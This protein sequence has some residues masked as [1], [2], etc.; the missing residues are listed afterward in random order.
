[1]PHP[2]RVFLFDLSDN[3]PILRLR[4]SGGA[5]FIQ[6]GER[7]VTDQETRDAMQRQVNNC[8]LANRSKRRSCEPRR[9]RDPRGTRA[10]RA[11]RLYCGRARSP[12]STRCVAT[13]WCQASVIE[14]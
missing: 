3:K 9:L 1:M 8:A 12:T 13:T 2:A 14:R 6:A 5:R 10:Q 7:D 4:R 11:E